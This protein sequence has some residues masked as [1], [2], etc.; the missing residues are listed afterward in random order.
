LL[1][2]SPRSTMKAK[3]NLEEKHNSA[4]AKALLSFAQFNRA[5]FPLCSQ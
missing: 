4:T 2:C 5:R 1:A 3:S